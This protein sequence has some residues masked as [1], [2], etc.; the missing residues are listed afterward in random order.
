MA[1]FDKRLRQAT[2][3]ND[4]FFGG[5]SIILVAD[6][7]QLLPVSGPPLYQIPTK[8]ILGKIGLNCYKQ[9]QYAIRLQNCERQTN[10]NTENK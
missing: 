3:K 6:P 10:E 4:L 8:S 1:Q 2:D 5:L 7:G 9:F